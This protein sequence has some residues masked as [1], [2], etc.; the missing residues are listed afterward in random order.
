MSKELSLADRIRT[1]VDDHGNFTMDL[2]T[3]TGDVYSHLEGNHGG[4]SFD[5]DTLPLPVSVVFDFRIHTR[6]K[7]K[8]G[9]YGEIFQS[10]EAL[11]DQTCKFEVGSVMCAYASEGM[12][13]ALRVMEQKFPSFF[14]RVNVPSGEIVE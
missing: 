7:A 3:N 2:L 12:D 10:C 8:E 11:G 1:H 6:S 9:Q 4:T 14:T 5:I 13:E